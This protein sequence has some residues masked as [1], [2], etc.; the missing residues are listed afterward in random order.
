MG[1]SGWDNPGNLHRPTANANVNAE[2]KCYIA[3]LHEEKFAEVKKFCILLK[4]RILTF[5]KQSLRLKNLQS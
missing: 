3:S 2:A 4:K 1:G 5:F